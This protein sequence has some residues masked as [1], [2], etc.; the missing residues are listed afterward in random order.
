MK[1]LYYSLSLFIIGLLAY[2]VLSKVTGKEGLTNDDDS[3]CETNVKTLVYKNSGTIQ[4]LE[5]KVKQLMKQ[6]NQLIISD[7][8]QTSQIQKIQQL[9]TKYDSLAEKADELANENKQRLI[10]M[11]K[12][13]KAK[14]DAAQQ[15]SNKIKFSK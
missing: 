3:S 13:S 7:D 14:M 5:D 9:E 12:Q 6:V 10:A 15:Q 11:A 2:S 8:K 4:S 1:Y